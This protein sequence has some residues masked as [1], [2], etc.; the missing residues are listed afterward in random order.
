MSS[1]TVPVGRLGPLGQKGGVARPLTPEP[2]LGLHPTGSHFSPSSVLQAGAILCEGHP[3]FQPG[4]GT[5]GTPRPSEGA[6]RTP[7][8]PAGPTHILTPP[9]GQRP[10]S[11]EE[12]WGWEA[13]AQ[14]FHKK[15]TWSLSPFLA[16]GS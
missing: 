5:C 3:D 14:N 11:L 16:P 9:S 1:A 4:R 6:G 15:R 8:P 13:A 10:R 12:R 2:P 7:Q